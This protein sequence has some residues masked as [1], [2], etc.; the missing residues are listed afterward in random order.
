MVRAPSVISANDCARAHTITTHAHTSKIK[1]VI[2]LFIATYDYY[3]NTQNT[4]TLTKLSFNSTQ[5]SNCLVFISFSKTLAAFNVV[6]S[7]FVGEF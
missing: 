3:S 7:R 1:R 4:A 2:I 6:D 5:K